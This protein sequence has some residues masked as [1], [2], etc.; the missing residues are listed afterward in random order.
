MKTVAIAELKAKLSQYLD[1]VKQ[2]EEVSVTDRGHPVALIVPAARSG[3]SPSEL[4]DMV[5]AGIIRPGRGPV[6]RRLR[7]RMPKAK[8]PKGTVLRALLEEREKDR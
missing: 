5:R 2:G 6:P 3:P 1:T 7:E 4:H 8:D